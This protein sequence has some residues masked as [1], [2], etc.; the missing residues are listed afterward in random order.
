M[1]SLD[2][3]TYICNTTVQMMDLRGISVNCLVVK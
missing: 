1:L 3:S 2:N